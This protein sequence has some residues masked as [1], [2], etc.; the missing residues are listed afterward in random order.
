MPRRPRSLLAWVLPSLVALAGLSSGCAHRHETVA[1]PTYEPMVVETTVE[2]PGQQV[3]LA[4]NGYGGGGVA[5]VNAGA[6]PIDDYAVI[7]ESYDAV[8]ADNADYVGYETLSSG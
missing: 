6:G 4:D 7:Q 3:Y 8:N 1:A 2:I 5:Q